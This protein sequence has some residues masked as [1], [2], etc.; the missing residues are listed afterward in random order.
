LLIV[1]SHPSL[2]LFVCFS[3]YALSGVVR[4]LP[5]WKRRRPAETIE[6]PAPGKH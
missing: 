6:Q 2:F 1:A 5:F 4:M 3:A